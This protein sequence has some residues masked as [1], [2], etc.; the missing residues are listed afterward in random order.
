MFTR[1]YL[2]PS[3]VWK[4]RQM[5]PGTTTTAISFAYMAA[6][7]AELCSQT[8]GFFENLENTPTCW[9]IFSMVYQC[10]SSFSPVWILFIFPFSW[11]FHQPNWRSHI[12]QRGRYTTDQSFSLLKWQLF[13][14]PTFVSSQAGHLKI[15]PMLGRNW[16]DK[17]HHI[18]VNKDTFET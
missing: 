11:E 3:P 10:L 16:V 13:L 5:S 2:S 9:Y 6:M 4:S 12:F 14:G 17:K 7:Q 8:T 1:G 18:R 15:W